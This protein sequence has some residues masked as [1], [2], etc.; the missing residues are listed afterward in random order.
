MSIVGFT[1]STTSAKVYPAP[2]RGEDHSATS[3]AGAGVGHLEVEQLRGVL[4]QQALDAQC[5]DSASCFIGS[6]P[7]PHHLVAHHVRYTDSGGAR[8]MNDHALVAHRAP[9]GLDRGERGSHHHCGGPCIS[10][11]NVHTWPA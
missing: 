5:P 4:S 8:A 7:F 1:F 2:P 10:S 11:L 3:P 6:E 9:G